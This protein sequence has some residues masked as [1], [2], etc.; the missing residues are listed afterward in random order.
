MSWRLYC[1]WLLT[2]YIANVASPAFVV[3]GPEFNEAPL[4]CN[5]I[6]INRTLRIRVLAVGSV[7]DGKAW[8]LFVNIVFTILYRY[9]WFRYPVIKATIDIGQSR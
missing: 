3:E 2:N 9:T 4:Q 8:E 1:P 5:S 6:F 7:P